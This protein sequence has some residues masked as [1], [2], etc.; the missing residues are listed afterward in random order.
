MLRRVEEP[1]QT[2][3]YD[4]MVLRRQPPVP[5]V[6]CCVPISGRASWPCGHRS[7][8]CHGGSQQCDACG[9]RYCQHHFDVH[10]RRFYVPVDTWRAFRRGFHAAVQ[11][12]V[13]GGN[14][15]TPIRLPKP[16]VHAEAL[17]G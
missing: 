10:V 1:V 3:S 15:S 13:E 8:K 7:A 16:E 4:G 17:E 9:Y 2:F 12:I 6:Y 5:V 11:A 14:R